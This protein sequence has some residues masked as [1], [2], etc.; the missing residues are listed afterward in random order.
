[1][2]LVS[3]TRKLNRRHLFFLNNWWYDLFHSAHIGNKE[4]KKTP[5]NHTH[6]HT[7]QGSTDA[8]PSINANVKANGVRDKC[9]LD[10]N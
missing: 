2:F 4:G 10:N 3:L 1:M 7:S 9:S 5:K 8:I 6:T